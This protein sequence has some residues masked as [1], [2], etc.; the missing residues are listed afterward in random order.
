MEQFLQKETAGLPNWVWLVVV[1]GGIGAVYIA[2][3]LFGNKSTSASTAGA[4][5]GGGVSGLGG[6]IPGGPY[7]GGSTPTSSTSPGVGSELEGVIREAT[8]TGPV[9]GYDQNFANRGVPI[10]ATPGGA[11]QGYQMF[12]SRVQVIGPAVQGPNDQ[13]STLWYPI[14][15]GGY[16]SSYDFAGNPTLTN[17]PYATSTQ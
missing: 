6:Y 13:G 12:G 17:W 10:R 14:A 7:A 15:G 3:K 16:I 11:T 4:D 2:P 8:T 9:A 5:T 1:I